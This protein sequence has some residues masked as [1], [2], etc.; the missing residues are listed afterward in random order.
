MICDYMLVRSDW[1]VLCNVW[2]GA[3]VRLRIIDMTQDSIPPRPWALS[4]R[5]SETRTVHTVA[6]DDGPIMSSGCLATTKHIVRCVNAHEAL[7]RVVREARQYVAQAAC[8]HGA[9]GHLAEKTLAML[10]MALAKVSQ[11]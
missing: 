5:H 8:R 11:S 3:M 2:L 1:H 4:T 9:Q 7:V 10:D 6:N